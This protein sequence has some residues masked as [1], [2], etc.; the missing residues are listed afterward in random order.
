MLKYKWLIDGKVNGGEDNS[1]YL[2]TIFFIWR[3]LGNEKISLMRYRI[4]CSYPPNIPTPVLH[5]TKTTGG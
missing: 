2:S 3:V 5:Y 4:I 1:P